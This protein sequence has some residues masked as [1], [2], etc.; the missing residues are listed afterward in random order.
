MKISAL[1]LFVITQQYVECPT[2]AG[3]NKFLR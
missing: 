2:L 1:V 3:G